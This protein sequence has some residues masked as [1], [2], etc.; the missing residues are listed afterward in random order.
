MLTFERLEDSLVVS[1]WSQH[2]FAQGKKVVVERDEAVNV[3]HV[4]DRPADGLDGFAV[5]RVVGTI[6]GRI[7][8]LFPPGADDVGVETVGNR[9]YAVEV[10]A[11]E[12]RVDE[13]AF[14]VADEVGPYHRRRPMAGLEQ[15]FPYGKTEGLEFGVNL[16]R[17]DV[18]PV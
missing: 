17:G 6:H 13:G 11:I 4:A 8:P 15:A 5:D 9:S 7:V 2:V 18:G 12:A 16:V 3:A 1:E 10:N 14:D